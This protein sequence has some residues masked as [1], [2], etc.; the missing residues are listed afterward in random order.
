MLNSKRWSCAPGGERIRVLG[1][2]DA[3]AGGRKGGRWRRAEYATEGV[4]TLAGRR[5][6]LGGEWWQE[7]ASCC[8]GPTEAEPRALGVEGAKGSGRRSEGVL[9]PGLPEDRRH[10]GSVRWGSRASVQVAPQ[11]SAALEREPGRG[12][13]WKKWRSWLAIV[14]SARATSKMQSAVQCSAV[15]RLL[16]A[17]QLQRW[18]QHA[19]G[20]IFARGMLK[21]E[22]FRLAWTGDT[23]DYVQALVKH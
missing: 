21:G 6:R 7:E 2:G 10:L 23:W 22:T 4:C 16:L 13:E 20:S 14:H 19:I 5:R 1:L 12:G 11:M 15:C 9:R 18:V 8:A 3:A 17:C